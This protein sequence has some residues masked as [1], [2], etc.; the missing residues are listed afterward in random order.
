[1]FWEKSILSKMVIGIL[2]PLIVMLIIAAVIISINVGATTKQLTRDE[3]TASSEAASYQVSEFFTQY[4]SVVTQMAMN[5]E[6]VT[7]L[8][9]VMAGET[10]KEAD[11]YF[12]VSATLD[13]ILSN[14]PDNITLVWLVDLDSGESIRSGGVIKGMPDYDITTRSWYTELMEKK[15]LF[16]TEPYEDSSTG[17]MVV[18]ILNPVYKGDKLIGAAA[19]DLTLDKIGTIMDGLKLGETGFFILTS[20]QGTILH[21]PD[22]AF[23]GKNVTETGLSD[24][25]ASAI[26]EKKT[27]ELNYDLDGQTIHGSLASIGS[28]GWS[29]LTGLPNKEYMTPYNR[30]RAVIAVCFILGVI[31]ITAMVIFIS[32]GT[33][34]PLKKLSAIADE[35]AKGN[36][37]VEVSVDTEDETAQMAEAI[38]RTVVRLQDYICYIDEIAHVLNQIAD[39]NLKFELKYDY[40]G[41][42]SIIKEAL[43]NI[44][45]TL[46]EVIQKISL[47]ADEV[48]IGANHIAMGASALAE[49]A[50]EQAN[51][52]DELT[53]STTTIYEQIKENAQNAQISTS[54]VEE[55]G[56]SMESSNARMEQAMQTMEDI[57][58]AF[59][60]I[61]QI[62][63]DIESISTQTNLLSLNA[64]IESARA[65]EAGKGF[66]VVADEVRSLS[67]ESAGA[68][69][70]TKALVA[71]S[72][73][74]V[75]KGEMIIQEIAKELND[76]VE[77]SRE[78]T[79]LMEKVRKASTMQAESFSEIT[80]GMEQISNVVQSTAAT[81]EENSASS[82][83]LAAQSNILGELVK[84]FVL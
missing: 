43:L 23:K 21:F 74:V 79:E 41:E 51:T 25:V 34:K 6:V 63:T 65:G 20:P 29:V 73:A 67:N 14:D 68:V 49:G 50:A 18:S 17:T 46:T 45:V 75:H 72:E 80:K 28:T 33:I 52:V 76:V 55:T 16:I 15:K 48:Q 13:N 83:E 26:T 10:A 4:N 81:S 61:S 7:L 44:S 8:D 53:S 22:S 60:K 82:E 64:A 71:E 24:N 1:M 62:I 47:S 38:K 59:G 27:G 42:F 30:V 37:N 36:L 31:L 54:F 70:K 32:T 39:G 2:A 35:I 12:S 5:Q 40:Q 69:N 66:A 19:I 56:K 58:D 77:K 57:S 11:N 9:E 78:A 3:L 84:K